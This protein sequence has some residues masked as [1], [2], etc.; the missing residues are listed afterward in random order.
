MQREAAQCDHRLLQRVDAQLGVIPR[1]AAGGPLGAVRVEG[2]AHGRLQH[3]KLVLQLEAG[4][5]HLLGAELME[6]WARLQCCEQ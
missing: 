4:A 3:G 1:P 2:R 5:A 6:R